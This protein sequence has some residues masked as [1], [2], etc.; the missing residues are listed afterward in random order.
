[1]VRLGGPLRLGDMMTT[2]ENRC[3]SPE[4]GRAW[5]AWDSKAARRSVRGEPGGGTTDP[6]QSMGHRSQRR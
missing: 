4:R 6:V 1:M 3:R 5:C 2:R